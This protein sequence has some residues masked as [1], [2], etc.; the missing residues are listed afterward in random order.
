MTKDKVDFA[1]LFKEKKFS[2]ILSI[3][4]KI[5]EDKKN[6]GLYNLSGVSKMSISHS[7][8]SLESAIEDFRKAYLK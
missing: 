4:D 3:I 7:N 6:S 1:K 5:E 8:V 2:L